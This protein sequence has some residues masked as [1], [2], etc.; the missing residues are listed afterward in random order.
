M[1]T[2]TVYDLTALMASLDAQGEHPDLVEAIRR[3]AD[4][5]SAHR[6]LDEALEA[7]RL[8]RRLTSGFDDTA[9]DDSDLTTIVGSLMTSAII[10][11]A[12]STDTTPIDR[13][14]WFGE[15]KLPPSLRPVHRE[16]MRLRNKEVAHFGKG[17][18]VDGAP[19]LSEALVLRPFDS[20]YPIG[21]LSSRAHNRAALARRAEKLLEAVLELALAAVNERHTEVFALLRSLAEARDPVMALLRSMPLTD[22]RL[23][24]AETSTQTAGARPGAA[25]NFSRVAVVEIH[26]TPPPEDDQAAT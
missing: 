23:V 7:I 9:L 11:Y 2:Q 12:R 5:S 15:A 6:D 17:Q 13:R 16:L 19:L 25:R 10:L 21:H 20:N 24:A 3:A 8:L 14:Q 1:T 4:L 26:D 18:S 22:P